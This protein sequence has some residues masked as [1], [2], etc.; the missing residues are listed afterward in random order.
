VV[1]VQCSRGAYAEFERMRGLGDMVDDVTGDAPH[2]VALVSYG[3]EPDLLTGFTDDPKKLGD[4]FG[5][6][7]PCDDGGAVTLEAVDYAIHL[8]DDKD[9]PAAK[10][11]R[12]A[13][14]LISETR[15][16]GS[17]IKPAEVVA[18]LGRTNTVV[19]AVSFEPG[20]ESIAN[21]LLHGQ[22]GPGA[23]G[24]IV[25]AVQAL[26]R[27]VPETLAELS[28]GEYTVFASANKFDAGIHKLANHIHNFYLISF[29]PTSDTP[30]LH[31]LQVK[32]PDYPDARIHARLTYYQGNQPPPDIPE[33]D[34]H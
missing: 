32:I 4:A 30:G 28:G 34:K 15:D 17:Q 19:D 9:R 31:R 29:V 14:L 7:Q 5:Q 20:K 3:N 13:I 22:M 2:Q 12:R 18:N 23:I 16:H 27:N 11:N 6:L 26:K 24:L 8:F 33:K 1:V 10:G 21:S 25:M